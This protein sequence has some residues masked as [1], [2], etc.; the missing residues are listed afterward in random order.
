MRPLILLTAAVSL[1]LLTACGKTTPADEVAVAPMDAKVAELDMSAD[2][3]AEVPENALN[4]IDYAGTYTRDSDLGS[5]RLTLDPAEDS[6]EYTAP[7]GTV[8]RGSYTRMDD[9]KRL[10]FEDLDGRPAYFSVAEGSIYRLD[11]IDTPPD[12]ISVTSQYLRD[13]NSFVAAQPEPLETPEEVTE[14]AE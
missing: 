14:P 9:N 7:N 3:L 11:D 8:S 2:P 12:R 5:E 1:T 6:F 13:P 4:Q 10:S